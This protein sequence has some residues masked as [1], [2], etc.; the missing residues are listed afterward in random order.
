MLNHQRQSTEGHQSNEDQK[1]HIASNNTEYKFWQQPLLTHIFPFLRAV[2]EKNTFAL[3]VAVQKSLQWG[4]VTFDHILHL[5]RSQHYTTTHTEMYHCRQKHIL[6]RLPRCAGTRKVKLI[7]ILLKQKTRQWVAVAPA[8]PYA[9][10]HLT[11]HRYPCQYDTTQFFYEPDALSATQPTAPKNWRKVTEYTEQ[12][13]KT[14][15]VMQVVKGNR[16]STEEK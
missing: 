2:S 4:H 9:S 15:A 6:L 1:Q 7:W 16:K 10:L 8:E 3:H 13:T 14:T 12:Q 11:L 5:H